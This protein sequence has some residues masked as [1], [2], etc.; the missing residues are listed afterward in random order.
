MDNNLKINSESKN[1][2]YVT[3]NQEYGSTIMNSLNKHS[4]LRSANDLSKNPS[5]KCASEKN[6]LQ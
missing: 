4:R 5:E 6:A 1:L 3:S 2:P